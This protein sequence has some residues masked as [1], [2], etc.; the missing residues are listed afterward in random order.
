[1]TSKESAIALLKDTSY[2]YD[3][4][5]KLLDALSGESAKIAT[6]SCSCVNRRRKGVET[7][8]FLNHVVLCFKLCLYNMLCSFQ[9]RE[10]TL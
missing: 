6:F 4:S 8:I 1:M 10:Q 7:F 3:A 9:F 2:F 5:D